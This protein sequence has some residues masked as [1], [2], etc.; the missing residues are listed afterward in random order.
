MDIYA[1]ERVQQSLKQEYAYIFTEKKYPGVPELKFHTIAEKAF[2]V[3]GIKIIP[4]RAMHHELPI[5]G[6]RIKDFTYLT[7]IN[8]IPEKEKEKILGSKHIAITGLRKY[9]HLSHFSLDESLAMLKELSPEF[10][11]ITHCSHQLGLY[12]EVQAELPPNIVLAYDGLKIN[13]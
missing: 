12:T 8:F 13:C 2:E 3:E 10:G 1:E 7:D 11:Y 9:H 6:F 5:L 4:I